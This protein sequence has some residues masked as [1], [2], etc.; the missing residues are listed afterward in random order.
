VSGQ[1]ETLVPRHRARKDRRR[2]CRG[3]NGTPHDW[4]VWYIAYKH[5]NCPVCSVIERSDC[6]RCGKKRLRRTRAGAA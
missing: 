5:I 1:P 6:R 4:G 2:W 3:R